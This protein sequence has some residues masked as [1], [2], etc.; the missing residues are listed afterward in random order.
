MKLNKDNRLL[1]TI[2]AMDIAFC[3]FAYIVVDELVKQYGTKVYVALIALCIF[4]VLGISARYQ[5]KHY[6]DNDDR[7]TE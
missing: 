6:N 2:L 7:G 3:V 5:M 1:L 4:F